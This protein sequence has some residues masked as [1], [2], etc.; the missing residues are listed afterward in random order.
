MVIT[1]KG[2]AISK[3]G[4]IQKFADALGWNRNRALRIVNGVQSP[5]DVDIEQMAKALEISTPDTFM[6][7]FFADMYTMCTNKNRKDG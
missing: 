5:T 2:L 1:L 7:I 4:S 6:Q 3:F